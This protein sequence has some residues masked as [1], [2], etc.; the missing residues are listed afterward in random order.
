MNEIT[1][2]V[3]SRIKNPNHVVEMTGILFQMY[4]F[5]EEI[6]SCDQEIQSLSKQI[7]DIDIVY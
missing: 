4:Y 2:L 6:E 1:H 3:E 7:N 5:Q